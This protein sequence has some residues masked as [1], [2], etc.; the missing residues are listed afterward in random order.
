MSDPHP[1]CPVAELPPGER[2]IVEIDGESIGV[3]NVAGEFHALRNVCP[4]HLAPLCEGTIG[5]TLSPADAVGEYNWEK[6]GEIIRCP[7]HK[8]EFDIKTGESVYNPHRLR[9]RT[10]DTDV[11]SRP[12]QNEE[13]TATP[14]SGKAT[15]TPPETAADERAAHDEPN[16]CRTELCEDAPPIET[17]DTDVRDEIVVVYV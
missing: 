4:H 10:Y 14:Q 2:R 15:Q 13:P 1:V 7:W 11:E 9:T 3:F 6:E 17:Y 16:D 8:W 5:G 12:A